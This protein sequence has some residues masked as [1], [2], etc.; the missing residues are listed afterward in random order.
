[1]KMQLHQLRYFV[2]V[3][4]VRHFTQAA[5]IVGITQPS[6]SK[7]V[8]ALETT[9]G[10]PLF[11]RV[12]GNIALTAAGE[13]L[14]PLAK[15]ILAD[16]DTATREVQELVG[17]RRGRVRLG[18]TPSLATSLA[19]PVLRRFRDAHPAVDLRV[20][21]GGSQD[22][23]RD[24]LRG[25]LD[26]ALIIMPA[27]GADPGLRVDP[28]LRESL[29]IASVEPLP[30]ALVSGELRITDLRDQPLVMFRE[31]YDLRDATIQACREAGFEPTFSVDGGEMDAVLS[32]VEAGLGIALVP[33]IVVSRRPGIRVTRLAPPGVRRTIAVARRRDVVPTHAGRELRRILLDYVHAATSTSDL[34][35]GVEP[36]P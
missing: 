10:A 8:H 22:L 7:Q 35:P 6:L 24:L 3:A 32:F 1:M 16:V 25:D 9:L 2:A 13:V 36:L 5:D 26:L 14:L 28:I 34:P 33:G 31:G 15:R 18:A 11:E 27:Q 21:E 29:V 12:R 17:L 4:E 19:P 30:A 20:E 23:V